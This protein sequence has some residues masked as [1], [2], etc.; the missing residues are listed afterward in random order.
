MHSS[1]RL[2]PWAPCAVNRGNNK[3]GYVKCDQFYFFKKELIEFN[4]IGQ[5]ADGVFEI[6][7]DYINELISK[8]I[9]F[10]SITENLA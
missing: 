7:L 8:G 5:L 10:S 2:K 1:Q 6:I 9:E 3:N 4:V